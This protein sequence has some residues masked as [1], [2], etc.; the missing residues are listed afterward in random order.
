MLVL[1]SGTGIR[2]LGKTLELRDM[3]IFVLLTHIHWDHIQGFPFFAP[4]YQPKR[5]IYIFPLKVERILCSL[6]EQIDGAHF[7]VTSDNLPSQC[8]F[9]RRNAMSF[10]RE[11]GFSTSRIAVNHK[12]GGYGYRIADAGRSVV[13]LT[14]NELDPPLD[15]KSTDFDEF[16]QFC[17]RADVLIHD[18]QYVEQDMPH[19]HGWGHSLVSQACALAAAAEVKHLVL[20]HHDPDRTDDELDLIQEHARVWFRE[21]NHRIRCT[22]AYEGLVLNIQRNTKDEHKDSLHKQIGNSFFRQKSI[23]VG[24]HRI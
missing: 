3:E 10:L 15:G 14:D 9:I 22:A 21:N 2:E 19:K 8:H 17:K 12:G 23:G 4:I 1:D 5:K 18:A 6:I 13:Y 24:F 20:F 7:P 11:N 16:V